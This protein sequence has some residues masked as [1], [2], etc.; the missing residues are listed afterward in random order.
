MAVNATE[1]EIKYEAAAD[2]VLPSF[3]GLPQVARAE[4][5]ADEQLDADYFDTDDLRLISAGITLRRRQG[6][7]DE[8]WHLKLPAGTN[9]RRE[10]RLPLGQ[11]R[12]RV[13]AALARLVLVHSRGRDLKPV[14]RISTIRR[15]QLLVDGEGT[16]L[17]EV[18]SDDVTAR[19][20]GKTTRWHEVEIEL[21]GG[22][23]DVL[24]AAD[25]LLRRGG[26]HRSARSAKLERA[27]GLPETASVRERPG[28]SAGDVLLDYLEAQVSALKAYDPMVRTDEPDAVHQMRVTTRRIR[29]T[30]QSFPVVRGGDSGARAGELIAELRWLGGEL[31]AARDA[32]V[33]AARLEE[34]LAGLPAELV[35]GPVAARVRGHFAR[36]GAEALAAMGEALESAR[37]FALLDNLDQLLGQREELSTVLT[38][39]E[40]KN[41][42]RKT[43]KRTRRRMK[44]ALS[45][46]AGPGADVALHEARKAAKRARYAAEA[47]APAFGPRAREFARRMKNVQSVLGEHQDA[48]IARGAVREL[49]M[50]AHLEGENA[51]SYGVICER[52]TCAAGRL[53]K[54]A[55]RAWRS[56]SRQRVRRWLR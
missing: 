13:P 56:A 3:A 49:G 37:Y 50:A 36:I 33:L 8:G 40:L 38:S 7:H 55:R 16:S 2:A 18:A 51:F 35:V 28:T 5:A 43:C 12:R 17:A 22:G 11:A 14:A 10:I 32:E 39:T 20:L 24:D 1:T 21:T 23:R 31:G 25:E 53:R 42:V 19:A 41:A 4:A 47:V 15:R 48:V 44:H 52:E 30:L 6:G 46:P 34:R 9:T 26:L 45:L 29:S 54:Q 27:L